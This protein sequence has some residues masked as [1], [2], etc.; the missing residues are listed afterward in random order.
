[1]SI[2]WQVLSMSLCMKNRHILENSD[3]VCLV[4]KCPPDGNVGMEGQRQ[5]SCFTAEPFLLALEWCLAGTP[6]IHF[7]MCCQ[8]RSRDEG[9]PGRT[10]LGMVYSGCK[11]HQDGRRRHQWSCYPSLAWRP[12]LIWGLLSLWC[13][14]FFGWFSASLLL[15]YISHKDSSFNSEAS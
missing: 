2:H 6:G 11:C 9:C 10:A 15:L 3:M 1:M 4:C 8:K 13:C 7:S 14:L 5:P 12:R